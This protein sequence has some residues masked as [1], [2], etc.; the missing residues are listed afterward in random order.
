MRM[1]DVGQT[2]KYKVIDD[3]FRI[4]NIRKPIKRTIPISD[5]GDRDLRY[6]KSNLFLTLKKINTSE[7]S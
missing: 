6:L 4:N 7:K 1:D 3:Q 5:N 2:Y